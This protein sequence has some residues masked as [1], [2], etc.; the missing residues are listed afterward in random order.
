MATEE[1]ALGYWLETQRVDYRDVAKGDKKL[2]VRDAIILKGWH[3][4]QRSL[5]PQTRPLDPQA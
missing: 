3:P 1:V 4:V 2:K 5:D